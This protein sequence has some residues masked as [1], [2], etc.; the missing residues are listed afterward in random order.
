MSELKDRLRA[1]MTTAMKSRETER[2][3][4]LRMALTAVTNAEV[5]GD[6]ARELSDDEVIAVLERE[7]KK[8]RESAEAYD[9]AGRPEL[10]AKERTEAEII[11]EYLPAQLTDDE[12]E[13]IVR[14]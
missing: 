12:I 8:R 13:E 1:D 4:T 6:E 3:S 14:D 7:A 5:A 2:L 9:E 11:A 10:A